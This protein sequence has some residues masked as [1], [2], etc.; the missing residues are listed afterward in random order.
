MRG[1]ES[2]QGWTVLHLYY[3]IDRI[4]WRQQSIAEREEAVTEFSTWMKDR[5]SE[6]GL[7]LIAQAG[8]AKSD[9]A[10]IAIH[11]DLWRLQQLGQE[12]RA[13]AFGAHLQLS[14]LLPLF[15]G[16]ERVYH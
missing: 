4:A 10:I 13:T 16:S 15:D 12:I 9:F 14:L 11:A 6:D 3:N 7:Q 5:A 2:A 8:V 1:L